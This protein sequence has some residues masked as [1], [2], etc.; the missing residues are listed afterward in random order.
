MPD[1]KDSEADAAPQYDAYWAPYATAGREANTPGNPHWDQSIVEV[2]P[3]GTVTYGP[4]TY[5]PGAKNFDAN[6][7]VPQVVVEDA[8]VPAE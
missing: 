5:V 1:W 4:H 7:A 6:T 3:D 8:D 2:A